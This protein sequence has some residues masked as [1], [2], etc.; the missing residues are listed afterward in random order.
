MEKV[1]TSI[2]AAVGK[3]RNFFVRAAK[4]LNEKRRKIALC[5]TTFIVMNMMTVVTAFAESGGGSISNEGDTT[6]FALVGFFATWIGRIGLLV[7]FIGGTMFGFSFKSED[8]E[9][10]Q[11]GLT[12]L[13]AGFIVYALTRSMG[14][15]FSGADIPI[16]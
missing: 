9:A 6:F 2:P 14:L 8:A 15:F 4:K 11:R 13:V 3:R 10:K 16:L 5:V 7:A 12:T 1:N